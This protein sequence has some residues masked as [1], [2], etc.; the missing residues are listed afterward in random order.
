M[1]G[2]KILHSTFVYPSD[3][4]LIRLRALGFV[5]MVGLRDDRTGNVNPTATAWR[6]MFLFHHRS[7]L[8]EQLISITPHFTKTDLTDMTLPRHRK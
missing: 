1:E 3:T 2:R 6:R 8:N 4:V 7:L 5:A